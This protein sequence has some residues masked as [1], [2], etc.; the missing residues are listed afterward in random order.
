MI[1]WILDSL[2]EKMRFFFSELGLY[3]WKIFGKFKSIRRQKIC[4]LE[5][6]IFMKTAWTILTEKFDKFEEHLLHILIYR[7]YVTI[8]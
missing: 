3:L 1:L 8:C 5:N 6:I 2:K 4:L 7:K